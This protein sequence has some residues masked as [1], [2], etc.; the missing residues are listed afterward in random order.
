MTYLLQV[1]DWTRWFVGFGTIL[2][3]AG[4]LFACM[5]TTFDMRENPTDWDKKP[6]Y[7]LTSNCPQVLPARSRPRLR[8]A[9]PNS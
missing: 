2:A 9:D 4:F 8:L 5:V 3:F 7:F 6:Y 1:V